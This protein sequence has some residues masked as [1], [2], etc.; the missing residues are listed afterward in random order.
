MPARWVPVKV[1]WITED[2][3]C[4]V[5]PA[6]EGSVSV[7]RRWSVAPCVSADRFASARF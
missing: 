3:F 4:R 1:Y 7:T 5:L 2:W 6:L